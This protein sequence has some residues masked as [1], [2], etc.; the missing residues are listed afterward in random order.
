MW[1]KGTVNINK[2]NFSSSSFEIKK[3]QGRQIVSACKRK[4]KKRI[5]SERLELVLTGTYGIAEK[6]AR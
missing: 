6:A 3:K 2:Y 4:E 5:E 1:N